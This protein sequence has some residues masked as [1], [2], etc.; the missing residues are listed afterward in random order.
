MK[1]TE[2]T[3]QDMLPEYNF[4]YS[5]AKT[6]RFANKQP[7]ITV[8]LDPD[9]AA[10]FQNSAAVN[11]ALRAMLQFAARTSSLTNRTDMPASIIKA[12]IP[13]T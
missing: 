12:R 7:L 3:E 11:E 5:K 9:V 13:P 8:T 2:D 10:A 6:N 1:H 4:D